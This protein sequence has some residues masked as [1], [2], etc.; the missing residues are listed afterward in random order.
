MLN[1]NPMSTPSTFNLTSLP[2]IDA[3]KKLCKAI[4]ALDAIIC[5]EWQYRYYSYQN[6]WDLD[7]GEECMEMRN[8]SG[9]HFFVLFTPKGA[10]ING[11]AHES[12]MCNWKES[13]VKS[14]NPLIN[15]FG[16]KKLEL[17]QN[18]WPGL[19]DR[20]PVEF[21]HF[22]FG[23][24]IRSI[25][26]TFCIWRKYTDSKWEKGEFEYPDDDYKDGS[27]HLLF[28]LDNKP[29]TYQRFAVDYYEDEFEGDLN[30]LGIDLV[31]HIYN[32]DILTK[33]IALKIN[34][35]IDDFEKLKSDLSEISYPHSL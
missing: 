5:P 16:K 17:Q 11:Q 22:I 15:L 7:S 21:K 25:G 28:I 1:T 2:N 26:T 31:K 18:I 14:K 24:P 6:N 33:E 13:P 23:E 3:L 4:S 29:E 12:K 34:P 35:A 8:G 19:V 10:V 9:D 20:V 27:E 30:K 32:H